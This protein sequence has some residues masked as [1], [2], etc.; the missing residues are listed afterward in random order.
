[1]VVPS[2][3]QSTAIAKDKPIIK[4]KK[5]QALQ[6]LVETA[7]NKE[8]K[9]INEFDVPWEYF[10]HLIENNMSSYDFIKIDDHS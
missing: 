5:T 10:L 3:I 4:K 1:M 6:L 7:R 9:I 2:G 8:K